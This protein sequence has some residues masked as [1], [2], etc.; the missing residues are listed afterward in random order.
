MARYQPNLSEKEFKLVNFFLEKFMKKETEDYHIKVKEYVKQLNYGTKDVNLQ[1]A[2][3][4]AA[5][6][7]IVKLN[8]LHTLLKNGEAAIKKYHD[9]FVANSELMRPAVNKSLERIFELEADYVEPNL[10]KE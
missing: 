6:D 5:N 2:T 8:E 4:S 9:A 1:L 10:N 3:F 7:F